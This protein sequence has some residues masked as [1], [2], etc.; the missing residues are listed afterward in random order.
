[1]KISKMNIISKS[2]E[3]ELFLFQNDS[4]YFCPWG[5]PSEIIEIDKNL[6]SKIL[7]KYN[8][9]SYFFITY[10]IICITLDLLFFY[11]TEFVSYTYGFMASF[12]FPILLL[13][14]TMIK[15]KSKTEYQI[16]YKMGNKRFLFLFLS[17]YPLSFFVNA[18]IDPTSIDPITKTIYCIFSLFSIYGF[19]KIFITNGF[20]Y[21]K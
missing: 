7:F 19:L 18:Y 11:N 4:I 2:N 20:Y 16:N 21:T 8:I 10:I 3:K 6:K 12:I 17:L 9:F 13:Y 5:A 14:N 15:N 1:M